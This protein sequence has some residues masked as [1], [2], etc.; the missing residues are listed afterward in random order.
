MA[1]RERR[2]FAVGQLILV[3]VRLIRR[4]DHHRPDTRLSAGRPLA[5]SR[6]PEYCFRMWKSGCDWRF[7]QSSAP[8]DESPYRSR[9]PRW[10]VQAIAVVDI[11]AHHLD[12]STGRART[13]SHCGTQSRTRQTTSAPAP[14]TLREPPPTS[15]VAPVTKHG[16]VS[17]RNSASF[18]QFAVY[19]SARHGARFDARIWGTA[20]AFPPRLGGE[21][22]GPGRPNCHS[23]GERRT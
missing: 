23:P 20:W 2:I 12:L 22:P 21:T 13:S 9:I 19:S 8:P 7:R 15:P 3:P 4:G 14:A 5:C 16:P 10:C 6:R 11:A 18:P 17:A 1:P